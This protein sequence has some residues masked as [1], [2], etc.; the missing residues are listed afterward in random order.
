MTGLADL[1]TTLR[2]TPR[3]SSGLLISVVASLTLPTAAEADRMRHGYGTYSG[4]AERYD[5]NG[6]GKISQEEITANRQQWYSE[7]DTDK[8][9]D[10]SIAEFEKLW[11]KAR[12]EQMVREFQH[13]DRD[14]DGKV[15]LEEY[16]RPMANTVANMDRNGDG[17]LSDEDR[18]RYRLRAPA[19]TGQ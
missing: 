15:T 11:L 19:N 10:L 17:V 7:F 18:R 3:L 12:R 8:S 5:A 2:L 9:S 13:F 14:G 6:D 16:Q 1:A 4:L